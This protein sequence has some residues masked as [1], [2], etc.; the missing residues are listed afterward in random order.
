MTTHAGLSWLADLNQVEGKAGKGLG[1]LGFIFKAKS[2]LPIK[3]EVL[4]Y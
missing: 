3:N 4:L 1:M 2:R